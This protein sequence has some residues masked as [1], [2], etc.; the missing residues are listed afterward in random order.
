MP[1]PGQINQTPSPTQP[2][3]SRRKRVRELFQVWA[4]WVYTC[5]FSPQGPGEGLRD[6]ESGQPCCKAGEEGPESGRPHCFCTL[7]WCKLSSGTAHTST[8]PGIYLG[9][10]HRIELPAT[11]NHCIIIDCPAKDALWLKKKP[12]VL[13]QF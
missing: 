2:S 5:K 1:R 3:R 9:K 11:G 12:I 13:C 7:A 8:V 10:L 4:F 6:G